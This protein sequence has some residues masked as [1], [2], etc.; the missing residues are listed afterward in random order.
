MLAVARPTRKI[1]LQHVLHAQHRSRVAVSTDAR[2]S[3]DL[4]VTQAAA[5]A[6]DAMVRYRCTRVLLDYVSLDIPRCCQS[7]TVS[8]DVR[9]SFDLPA[10]RLRLPLLRWSQGFAAA[11]RGSCLTT[12]LVAVK[13]VTVSIDARLSF[14]L[15]LRSLDSDC[16]CCAGRNGSLPLH[17]GVA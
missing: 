4:L 7:V 16:R 8:D 5:V 15:L 13:S 6:L 11:T 9:L 12:S 10:A 17:T 14:D 3:F 2:L 1:Q